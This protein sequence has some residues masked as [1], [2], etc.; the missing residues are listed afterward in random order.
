MVKF[1][2]DDGTKINLHY[3]G[4]EVNVAARLEAAGEADGILMS[5]E[6]Y[7]HVKIL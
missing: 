3:I 4:G 5:Y 2:K 6:T 1:F 7:A